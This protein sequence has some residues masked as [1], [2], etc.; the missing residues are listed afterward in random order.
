MT[1]GDK[2]YTYYFKE[3]VGILACFWGGKELNF[4][5]RNLFWQ[6]P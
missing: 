1:Y 5:E 4:L 6:Q 2:S 3:G